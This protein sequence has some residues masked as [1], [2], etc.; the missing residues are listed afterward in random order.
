VLSAVSRLVVYAAVA[1]SVPVLR[2][3]NDSKAQFLL[4]VP[5]FFSAAAL[6]F[7]LVLLT[8]MGKAELYVVGGT[9]AIALINW[10]FVRR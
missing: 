7:S 3:R 1:I 2:Q 8:R 10:L 9:S 6:V 5:Y 4:P